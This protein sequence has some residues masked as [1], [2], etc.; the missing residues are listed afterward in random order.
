MAVRD[1]IWFLDESKY[2]QERAMRERDDEVYVPYMK[3]A[4]RAKKWRPGV[5]AYLGAEYMR[6]KHTER[7]EL[8]KASASKTVADWGN[9]ES[10]RM[11]EE[12]ASVTHIQ[13][14]EA[15]EII[16][17]WGKAGLTVD[18]FK[19]LPA[20]GVVKRVGGS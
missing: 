1:V 18:S 11:F 3:L 7:V 12:S 17:G 14:E 9:T 15:K 8:A 4:R 20:D 19:E 5:A 13:L 16:A 2:F 10:V 6:R